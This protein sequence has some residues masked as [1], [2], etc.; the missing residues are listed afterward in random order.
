MSTGVVRCSLVQL[1]VWFGG[2]VRQQV[3]SGEVRC[4]VVCWYGGSAGVCGCCC[5]TAG[6]VSTLQV[7]LGV[8]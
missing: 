5:V 6:V 8:E 3:R 4:V 7:S 2:M 1:Q